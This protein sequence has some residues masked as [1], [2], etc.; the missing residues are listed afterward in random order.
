M[1]RERKRKGGV[2]TRYQ[3]RMKD[4]LTEIERERETGSLEFR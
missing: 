3:K 1:E 2:I 4:K